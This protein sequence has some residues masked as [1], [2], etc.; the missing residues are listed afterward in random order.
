MAIVRFSNEDYRPK[1][2]RS[3]TYRARVQS[4]NIPGNV[5]SVQLIDPTRGGYIFVPLRLFTSVS[6]L[7]IDGELLEVVLDYGGEPIRIQ[8]VTK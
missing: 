7:P 1:N 6:V 5:I 8:P 2:D 4:A 3:G